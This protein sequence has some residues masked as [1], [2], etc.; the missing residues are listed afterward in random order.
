MCTVQASIYVWHLISLKICISN[1]LNVSVSY[2]QFK[3]LLNPQKAC[4]CISC[5]FYYYKK[6]RW[7][8]LLMKTSPYLTIR[9][10][11]AHSEPYLCPSSIFKKPTMSW[12]LKHVSAL[13]CSA[14]EMIGFHELRNWCGFILLDMYVTISCETSRC[15]YAS[16]LK[17]E[18]H[19]WR[20]TI[21]WLPGK[22]NRS[23]LS[24][25]HRN[26]L[27]KDNVCARYFS[28]GF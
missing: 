23:V 1:Q 5:L 2:D 14:D 3:P 24:L 21:Y 10:D 13:H 6:T 16:L 4:K 7:L 17:T 9:K 19:W 25:L 27:Y 11:K 20:Q 8:P 26:L 18:N 28:D 12:N 15:G 22:Y